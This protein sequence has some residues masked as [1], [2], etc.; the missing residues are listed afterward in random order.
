MRSQALNEL[1][2]LLT[3]Q[4]ALGAGQTVEVP[5]GRHSPARLGPGCLGQQEDEQEQ[6]V[7]QEVVAN[8]HSR[9]RLRSALVVAVFRSAATHVSCS[10]GVTEVCVW[11]WALR[12]STGPARC[13]F[14]GPGKWFASGPDPFLMCELRNCVQCG[15]S[16]PAD[17]KFVISLR[18]CKWNREQGN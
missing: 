7:G 11:C 8:W 16:P 14:T 15:V 12:P 10:C 9:W 17:S 6:A 4:D 5:R 3:D 13:G 18:R 2:V 1:Y